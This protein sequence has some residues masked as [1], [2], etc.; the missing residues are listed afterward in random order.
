M[1]WMS[2]SL[3]SSMVTREIDLNMGTIVESRLGLSRNSQDKIQKWLL[4]KPWTSTWTFTIR[5]GQAFCSQES[6][7]KTKKSK[8]A[9]NYLFFALLS[10]AISALLSSLETIHG[11]GTRLEWVSCLQMRLDSTSEQDRS[12]MIVHRYIFHRSKMRFLLSRNPCFRHC[13]L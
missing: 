4:I 6:S 5:L 9:M 12:V 10:L 1:E 13:S 11:F 7:T 2:V 3:Q 8:R